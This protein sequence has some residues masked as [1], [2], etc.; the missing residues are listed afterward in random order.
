MKIIW[1]LLLQTKNA[2]T[3]L[4]QNTTTKKLD[5]IA[6]PKTHGQTYNKTR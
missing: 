4:Q 2:W 6:K 3:N 5:D 1:Q